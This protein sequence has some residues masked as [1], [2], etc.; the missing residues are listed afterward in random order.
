M[1]F[2]E[3]ETLIN[4]RSQIV[5]DIITDAGNYTVWDSGITDIRCRAR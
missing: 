5:W 1:Y 3:A 4:A 2:V